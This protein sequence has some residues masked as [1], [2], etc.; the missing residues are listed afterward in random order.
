MYFV[1]NYKYSTDNNIEYDKYI[2][3]HNEVII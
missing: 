3:F 2:R 1:L